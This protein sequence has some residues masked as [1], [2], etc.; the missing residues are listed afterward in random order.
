MRTSWPRTTS[1]TR[2][3][4]ERVR[5]DVGHRAKELH[6]ARTTRA[7]V[8]GDR[9][10]RAIG[11]PDEADDVVPPQLPSR[12]RERR[13]NPL[14][15]ESASAGLSRQRVADL[16]AGP[17]F[18]LVTA[19][20]TDQLA[21]LSLFD[22]PK[23]EAAQLPVTND[24]RQLTPRVRAIERLAIAKKPADLGIGH[25]SRV[26]LDVRWRERAKHQSQRLEA[27]H[28]DAQSAT[29]SLPRTA[30]IV[31]CMSSTATVAPSRSVVTSPLHTV[32]VR[33]DRTTQ[34]VA[35]KRSPTAGASMFTLNSTLS[36]PTPGSIRLSAA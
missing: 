33:P 35:T 8:L 12:V 13:C 27:R 29:P 1:S 25:H 24:L 9:D 15:R 31:A 3:R 18:G 32:S 6:V 2:S 10:R 28:H 11:G 21:R 17:P 34:P 22:G 20:A 16:E 4:T 14:A 30:I 5:V 23:S 26:G 36:T 19:D 7:E